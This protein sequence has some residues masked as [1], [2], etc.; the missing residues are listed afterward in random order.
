M[1]RSKQHSARR[2]PVCALMALL[3]LTVPAA[4]LYAADAATGGK[5]DG[6]PTV[7]AARAERTAFTETILVTGSLVARTEIMVAPQI[8]GFRLS[9]ILA[10]EGD[11]VKSGQVLARLAD[12]MLKVQLAQL[13]ASLVKAEASIAQARSRIAEAEANQKQADAAF[14]RAQDLVKSGS[15]SRSVYD[16]REA[17]S[18]T[19]AAA[20][21]L[22]RDGLLV[23]QAEKTQIEAQIRESRLRLGYT[24]IK[25]T[26]DGLISRRKARVGA[27]VSNSSEPLFRMVAKGEIELDAEV[28]EIYLPRITVGL[29]ARIDAAGLKPREGKVRLIS[30]EIDP[31][32]RLGRVRILIGD[33]PA[34]RVGSFAR[35]TIDTA[36]SSGLGVPSTAVLNR[37]SGAMVQVVKDGRVESRR[38]ATGMVSNGMVEILDGLRDGEIVVLRSG[39]LLRDGDAVRAVIA[40]TTTVSEAK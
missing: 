20:V 35:G 3:S 36:K 9:E 22:S 33:D 30:P 31:A 11:R 13:E 23:A 1:I 18:R 7:S 39:T 8:D 17:A 32:T 4:P 28:P 14:G 26:E 6:G 10:E 34:L 25:A 15:T 27:L 29:P 16:E 5:E 2:G 38:V 19:S 21:A 12:E 40:G 24:E 37:D